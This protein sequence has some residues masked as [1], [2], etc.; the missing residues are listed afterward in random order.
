M[1]SKFLI[2]L[3]FLFQLGLRP[4]VLYAVYKLG[5]LT[6][7]YKR[8]TPAAH[9]GLIPAYSSRLFSLPSREQLSQ[10]L[11]EEGKA[12]LLKEADEI[13]NGKFRLFGAELVD[14]DLTGDWKAMAELTIKLI[15]DDLLRKNMGRL[16]EEDAQIRFQMEKMVD[17]YIDWYS[18][19]LD[20]NVFGGM[21]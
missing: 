18:E 17:H 8:V 1:K 9:P 6:G 13:V 3:K 15:N 21:H 2:S 11:G 4:L 12:Y 20:K 7:H 14:I 19:I 16:A 10:I 5:L